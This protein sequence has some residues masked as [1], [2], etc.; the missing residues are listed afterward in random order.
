HREYWIEPFQIKASKWYRLRYPRLVLFAAPVD[1]L[2]GQ[3]PMHNNFQGWKRKAGVVTLVMAC[4]SALCWI[5]SE[6]T[7]DRLAIHHKSFIIRVDS[8]CSSTGVLWLVSGPI[9]PQRGPFPQVTWKSY[10]TSTLTMNHKQRLLSYSGI[11][12]WEWQ[13]CGFSISQRKQDH[14]RFQT[15]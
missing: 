5:R 2:K 13:L 10:P 8:F 3:I 7:H 11:P 15:V 1:N 4:A 6:Y 14:F 12:E 9:E